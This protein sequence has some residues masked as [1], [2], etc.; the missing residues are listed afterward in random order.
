MMFNG[1]SCHAQLVHRLKKGQ[2][3]EFLTIIFSIAY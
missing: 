1:V 3:D 2:R